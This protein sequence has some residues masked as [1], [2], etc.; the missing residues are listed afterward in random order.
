M[1]TD[2]GL[3]LGYATYWLPDLGKQV[4]LSSQ[5]NNSNQHFL[6]TY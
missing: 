5:N 2:L 1:K 3:N 4:H 6:S